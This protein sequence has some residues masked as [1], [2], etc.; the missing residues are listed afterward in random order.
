MKSESIKEGF[1][2]DFMCV[3][4]QKCGTSTLYETLKQHSGI[5]LSNIK[6][7][8][9]AEWVDKSS[10]PIK[11]IQ[12]KFFEDEWHNKKIG[13]IDPTFANDV[14]LAYKFIGKKTKLI[15]IM[16]NPVDRLFS[17][18]KMAL[19]LGYN[20]VY[21][22]TLY[23]KEI[24]RVR[25]SFGRYVREELR[26]E[27]KCNAI[28]RGNYLDT[29]LRFEKYYNRNMMKFIFLEDYITDPEK[30]V[31]EVEEFLE[32]PHEKLDYSIW[33]NKG[34]LVPKN[35]LAFK[36]NQSTISLREYVRS[37]P[38]FSAKQWYRVQR[39]S[40][41]IRKKTSVINHEKMSNNTRRQL[42]KYYESSIQRLGEYLDI[43]LSQ[44]WF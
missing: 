1:N 24:T 17:Y 27:N 33:K 3:G 13:I 7:I 4:I 11:D 39:M 2:I 22:S 26:K 32:L 40:A 38:R 21:P 23:G 37:N 9:L 25:W 35:K 34:D 6:E 16:R 43:D 14:E 12:R 15:F 20:D 31:R 44:I 29:I 36:V 41:I 30:V 42:E 10:D 19:R 28:L 18:Y 5:A 8:H